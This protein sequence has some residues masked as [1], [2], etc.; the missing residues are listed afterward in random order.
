MGFESAVR[1]AASKVL[2]KFG[3]ELTFRKYPP[4]T[5]DTATGTTTSVPVAET[6][7]VRFQDYTDRELSGAAGTIKAGD[8]KVLVAA[9]DLTF[10]PRADST[11]VV[12]D[13][14]EWDVIRV[15]QERA[16]DQPVLYTLQ[17]RR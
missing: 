11:K 14:E 2:G 7:P 9:A 13:A 1:K 16:K 6:A 5:Y 4:P 3:T 17:V 10:E 8:R 15:L 12:I